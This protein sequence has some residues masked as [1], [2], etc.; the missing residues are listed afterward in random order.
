MN[1]DVSNFDEVKED[2]RD[3]LFRKNLFNWPQWSEEPM[4]GKELLDLLVE[5]G[6]RDTGYSRI[7]TLRLLR[8]NR[9]NVFARH[10]TVANCY[11]SSLDKFWNKNPLQYIARIN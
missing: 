6:R 3:W 11:G 9:M 1:I 5:V 7:D 2:F 4:N 8:E 10:G